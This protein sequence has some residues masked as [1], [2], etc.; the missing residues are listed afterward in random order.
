MSFGGGRQSWPLPAETQ[1]VRCLLS[2]HALQPERAKDFA[3][4][5]GK[6]KNLG[7]WGSHPA[8]AVPAKCWLQGHGAGVQCNL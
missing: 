5:S 6:L 3:L 4:E 1:Q 2:Q 7:H 8:I